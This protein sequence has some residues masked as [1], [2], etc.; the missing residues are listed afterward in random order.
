MNYKVVLVQHGISAVSHHVCGKSGKQYGT[1]TQSPNDGGVAFEMTLEDYMVNRHDLIGNPAAGQQWVPE[2]VP[3]AS[4]DAFQSRGKCSSPQCRL[5]TG[6]SVAEADYISGRSLFCATHAPNDALPLYDGAPPIGL[7]PANAPTLQPEVEDV[8]PNLIERGAS[9]AMVDQ[10]GADA[11]K[12][13]LTP[14]VGTTTELESVTPVGGIETPVPMPNFPKKATAPVTATPTVFSDPGQSPAPAP[15]AE[16]AKL[17]EGVPTKTQPVAELL[18]GMVTKAVG[19]ALGGMEERLAALIEKKTTAKTATQKRR[20]PAPAKASDFQR[21]Q[22]KAKGLG[23]NP[24]GMGRVA[25][26]AAIDAK[27]NGT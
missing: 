11:P 1:A 3:K 26:E 18:E 13:V 24:Y 25:L 5:G 9:A 15:T 21:L 23:I 22:Q 6:G 7:L 2:F 27:G 8:R 14:Q 17:P 20:V 12:E 10:G 19:S 16:P 4:N